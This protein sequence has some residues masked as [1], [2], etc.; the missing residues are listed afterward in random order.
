MGAVAANSLRSVET[1]P[2]RPALDVIPPFPAVALKALN[3]LSGT[4]TCLREL[5][6]VIRPDA[7]FSAEILRLAN[8]PLIAFSKEITNVLQASMLLGFR[9]LRRLVIT[10]GLR[11][12][13]DQTSTLLQ[14]TWRHSVAC[15]MIAERMAR[16]NS[17]DR[18][19]AY[20]CGILHDVG[21]VVLATLDPE[22]YAALLNY[23]SESTTKMLQLERDTFEMDH[24]QAG[25]WLVS[26]WQL[27]EE[28]TAITAHHHEPLTRNDDAAELIRL[29]CMLADGLAFPAATN[30]S[31]PKLDE[32]MALVPDGIRAHLPPAEEWTAEISK[33]LA[34]IE[35]S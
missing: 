18:E 34:L 8:S 27:P 22:E 30:C 10:V 19:F 1:V 6:E 12:Y 33:E 9:R 20:T 29:S 16:W 11:S 26:A 7:V 28:F 13:L 2:V 24:C 14:S 4:D 17:V 15:A 31:C 25:S 23:R 35:A 32:V 21:R 3:V 5:C